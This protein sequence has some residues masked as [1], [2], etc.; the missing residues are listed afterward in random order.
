[1]ADHDDNNGNKSR[2]N[3]RNNSNDARI[4]PFE[5][6]LRRRFP[7]AADGNMPV[8]QPHQNTPSD[9]L[10]NTRLHTLRPVIEADIPTSPRAVMAAARMEMAAYFNYIADPHNAGLRILKGN[11][12]YKILDAVWRDD[13]GSIF[14]NM[15]LA[16]VP[17]LTRR[18]YWH[19]PGAMKDVSFLS[20]AHLARSMT[21]AVMIRKHGGDFSAPDSEGR[22]PLYYIARYGRDP[23]LVPYL[24]QEARV[25]L[26]NS[27]RATCDYNLDQPRGTRYEEPFLRAIRYANPAMVRGFTACAAKGLDLSG[28]RDNWGQTPLMLAVQEA[29]GALTGSH[30]GKA[31]QARRLWIVRALAATTEIE[32]TVKDLA[33][34]CAREYA[35]H[36]AVEKAFDEGVAAR[37][38]MPVAQ[39]M[40]LRRYPR[41]PQP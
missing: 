10:S 5:D 38:Q 35:L 1:M 4:V 16:G 29:N 12:H 8:A 28:A 18:W 21:M 19:F 14:A 6:F 9:M 22:T 15:A 31:E 24:A 17:D 41:G 39:T 11:P 33:G 27:G 34:N 26:R 13:I 40:T 7:A 32:Y 3:N 30:A 37:G 25:D 20:P 23:W 2:K 36:P